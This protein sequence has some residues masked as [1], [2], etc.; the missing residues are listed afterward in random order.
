[1]NSRVDIHVYHHCDPAVLAALAELKRIIIVTN[2]E[3]TAG[4]NTATA[5][6]AKI[7]G[8]TRSL[9]NKIDDLTTQIQNMDSVPQDVQDALAA[10]QSQVTIVDG[11]V[12]DP[13]ESA[14]SSPAP[15]PS[16]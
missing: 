9:L 11:L 14:V 10:L 16:V 4:L 8:E 12:P 7:G 13:V 1:M 6:I 3:L 5:Q 15:A 2:E